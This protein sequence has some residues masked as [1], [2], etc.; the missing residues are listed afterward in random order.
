MAKAYQIFE[1]KQ[2]SASPRIIWYA[3]LD[4][5]FFFLY[6]FHPIWFIKLKFQSSFIYSTVYH[7]YIVN[8]NF[9]VQIDQHTNGT[10]K[11]RMVAV[12]SLASIE[13]MRTPAIENLRPET[14]TEKTS[15]CNHSLIESKIPHLAFSPIRTPFTN[16]N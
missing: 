6:H 2:R 10:P 5:V 14:I 12:P 11:K 7:T 1:A 15:A 4:F 8:L 16:I 13:E 3:G 9:L